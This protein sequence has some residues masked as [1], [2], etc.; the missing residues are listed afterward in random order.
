M[1]YGILVTSSIIDVHFFGHK[2]NSKK[3]RMRQVLAQLI[4]K[5]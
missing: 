3:L 4:I 5:K 1:R 2:D